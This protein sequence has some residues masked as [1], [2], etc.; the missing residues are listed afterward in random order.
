MRPDTAT[1][2]I[3]CHAHTTQPH[4]NASSVSMAQRCQNQCA[5]QHIAAAT[6]FK[7]TGP[8]SH[9]L[10]THAVLC[11]ADL[12]PP[13][14]QVVSPLARH[15][16]RTFAL[17][18]PHQARPLADLAGAVV[19]AAPKHVPLGLPLHQ[20]L[21]GDE[22]GHLALAATHKAPRSPSA[23]AKVTHHWLLTQTSE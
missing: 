1:T 4:E 8:P 16:A 20:L 12:L 7:T 10:Q 14:C 5:L 22:G 21:P 19:P 23:L 18:A 15:V 17:A 2:R 9:H 6:W 13:T 3:L 11:S